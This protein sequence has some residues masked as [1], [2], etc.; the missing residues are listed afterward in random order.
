MA[1]KVPYLPARPTYYD[2]IDRM[3]ALFGPALYRSPLP[4]RFLTL[5]EL[6][7]LGIPD[8]LLKRAGDFHYTKNADA[9]FAGM[10]G[11]ELL[12]LLASSIQGTADKSFLR[13]APA[14]QHME[15]WLQQRGYTCVYYR[16]SATSES[17]LHDLDSH[18]DLASKNEVYARLIQERREAEQ[19]RIA[20]E[21]RRREERD[22]RRRDEK[23][24]E[25]ARARA[26][27]DEVESR[28]QRWEA[29]SHK[30]KE[31]SYTVLFVVGFA[32]VCVIATA[33]LGL[34]LGVGVILF[35]AALFGRGGGGNSKPPLEWG[36]PDGGP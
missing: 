29:M 27:R 18:S 31:Q 35:L 24:A 30:E 32:G 16:P 19:E 22:K 21:K 7:S 5:E 33:D 4:N 2:L 1:K 11:F 9:V 20:A 10:F 15:M 17:G 13:P 8:W 6:R 14:L 23:A 25:A 36:G 3:L 26:V 12:C 34:G 28:P